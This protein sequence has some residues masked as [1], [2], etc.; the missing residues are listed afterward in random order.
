MLDVVCEILSYFTTTGL[1]YFTGC[2]LPISTAHSTSLKCQ[3]A[4]KRQ[5]SKTEIYFMQYI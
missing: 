1:Q 2:L 4:Q 3:C 5:N